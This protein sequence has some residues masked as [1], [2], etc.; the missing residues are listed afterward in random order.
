ME[1]N[2]L[3]KSSSYLNLSLITVV[4]G[5]LFIAV[6]FVRALF[7]PLQHADFI[8]K[9]GLW[10]FFVELFSIFLSSL[11]SPRM[12]VIA[13]RNFI[14]AMTILLNFVGISVMILGFGYFVLHNLYIPGVFIASFLAKGFSKKAT[15][16][17]VWL[18]ISVLTV[19]IIGS[20][21][22]VNL[23]PFPE[24]F[25]RYAPLDVQERY[26]RGEIAGEFVDRPQTLLV[27]GALYFSVIAVMELFFAL[28]QS[29][30]KPTLTII[31]SSD[32]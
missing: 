28:R 3:K 32:G 16:I 2:L 20:Q 1:S 9:T 22:W 6:L 14:G 18:I 12:M 30:R 7:G 8:F 21:F 4:G 26:A 17:K 24:E 23:F 5:N 15:L 11:I 10:I 19:F 27:W 31:A 25:I 13:Q 29:L